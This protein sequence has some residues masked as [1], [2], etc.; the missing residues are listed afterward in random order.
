MLFQTIYFWYCC[1]SFETDGRTD[2]RTRI[3]PVR[4]RRQH[5]SREI[6]LVWMYIVL[7]ASCDLVA[8]S[9]HHDM[10]TCYRYRWSVEYLSVKRHVYNNQGSGLFNELSNLVVCLFVCF[11]QRVGRHTRFTWPLEQI[12]FKSQLPVYY[13]VVNQISFNRMGWEGN[14]S[15]ISKCQRL[16]ILWKKKWVTWRSQ[17][18]H[19]VRFPVYLPSKRCGLINLHL[20]VFL[21]NEK[22][23]GEKE[24]IPWLMIAWRGRGRG[25]SDAV[26]IDNSGCATA[27]K[28]NNNPTCNWQS[29]RVL[30]CFVFH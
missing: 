15:N 25:R 5:A 28:N 27:R 26:E 29:V 21:V 6:V 23:A 17:S 10:D 22:L 7:W 4:R 16:S 19:Y 18:T 20:V 12:N 30:F 24:L 14:I 11:T 9:S 1:L 13:L 8:V 2:G 3:P